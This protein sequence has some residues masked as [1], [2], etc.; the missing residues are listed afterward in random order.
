MLLYTEYILKIS[1]MLGD[2]AQKPTVHYLLL[3]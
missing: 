2:L 3:V 1:L